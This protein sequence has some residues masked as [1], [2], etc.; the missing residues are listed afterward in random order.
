MIKNARASQRRTISLNLKPNTMKKNTVQRYDYFLILA[1]F[2]RVFFA[3]SVFL[4]YLCTENFKA[5]WNKSNYNF[6][7]S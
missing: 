2:T 6:A 4:S 1:N 5:L 3:Y 7:K